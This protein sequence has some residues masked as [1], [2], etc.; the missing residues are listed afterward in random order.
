[1][2]RWVQKEAPGEYTQTDVAGLLV[3]SIFGSVH[4]AGT[5]RTPLSYWIV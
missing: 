1:M 4:T 2:W 3:S 5:V